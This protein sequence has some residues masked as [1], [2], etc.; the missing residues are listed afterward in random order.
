MADTP[1]PLAELD[2]VVRAEWCSACNHTGGGNGKPCGP[3]GQHL[4]RYI[5]ASDSGRITPSEMSRVFALIEDR[6]PFNHIV[7]EVTA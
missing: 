5:R 6:D 4:A 2:I 7:I 3:K 1:R